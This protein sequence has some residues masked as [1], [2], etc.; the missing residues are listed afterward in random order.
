VV[1]GSCIPVA[2]RVTPSNSRSGPA[3][4]TS[5]SV[6]IA[7]GTG[8]VGKAELPIV[9]VTFAG[10]V[11]VESPQKGRRFELAVTFTAQPEREPARVSM[12]LASASKTGP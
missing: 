2:G 12:I 11:P 6:V 10:C 7:N 5:V 3:Q 1:L 8:I 4:P 9:N